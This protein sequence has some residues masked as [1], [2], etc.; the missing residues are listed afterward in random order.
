[1]KGDKSRQTRSQK[2]EEEKKKWNNGKKHKRKRDTAKNNGNCEDSAR[3]HEHVCS[4]HRI[5]LF[6]RDAIAYYCPEEKQR[7][8][9]ETDWMTMRGEGVDKIGKNRDGKRAGMYRVELFFFCVC[10]KQVAVKSW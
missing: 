4:V 1:M 10:V 2:G 7:G 6:S 5:P 3:V 9:R 8:N